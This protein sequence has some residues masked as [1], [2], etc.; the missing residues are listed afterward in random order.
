MIEQEGIR[1][2]VAQAIDL[3]LSVLTADGRTHILDIIM[4]APGQVPTV[5]YMGNNILLDRALKAAFEA[6]TKANTGLI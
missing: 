1:V 5:T 3:K 4:D 6:T 2:P